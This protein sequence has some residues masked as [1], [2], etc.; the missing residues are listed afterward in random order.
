MKAWRQLLY[1]MS[2]Y[3]GQ[4]ASMAELITTG[5]GRADYLMFIDGTRPGAVEAKPSAT[6]L[7]SSLHCASR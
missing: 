5:H 2:L 7:A 1:E 6:R 4:G 3:A